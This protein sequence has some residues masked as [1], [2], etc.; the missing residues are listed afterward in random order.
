MFVLTVERDKGHVSIRV[1]SSYTNVPVISHF[2]T[3]HATVI[4]AHI[5][6]QGY[7]WN[8]VLGVN[9]DHRPAWEIFVFLSSVDIGLVSC[10]IVRQK[11]NVVNFSIALRWSPQIT[12]EDRI[13]FLLT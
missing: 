1:T 4:R 11:I 13:C 3:H 9:H 10:K 2:L 8:N 12:L 7:K 6:T 5:L